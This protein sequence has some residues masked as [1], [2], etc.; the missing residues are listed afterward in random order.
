LSF[1]K[2]AIVNFALFEPTTSE[3]VIKFVVPS[4]FRPVYVQPVIKAE[5]MFALVLANEIV[6]PVT[7][8]IDP[9]PPTP[10]VL[11]AILKEA[12]EQPVVVILSPTTKPGFELKIKVATLSLNE[13]AVIVGTTDRTKEMVFA[14]SFP[15]ATGSLNRKIKFDAMPAWVSPGNGVIAV[16]VGAALSVPI[17]AINGIPMLRLPTA[18]AA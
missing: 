18:S 10:R 7:A 12:F 16:K 4:A 17:V 13:P 1:G 3:V 2:L 6:L 15:M 9:S 11:A 5:P 14:A 8:V